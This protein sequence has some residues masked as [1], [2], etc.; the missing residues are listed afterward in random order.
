MSLVNADGHR[1]TAPLIDLQQAGARIRVISS[2]SRQSLLRRNRK[3]LRFCVHASGERCIRSILVTY[4]LLCD[5]SRS[6]G[7]VDTSEK[8][9]P[10]T[11]AGW[12]LR[13]LATTCAPAKTAA[14][15]AGRRCRRTGRAVRYR[16]EAP[17]VQP[18]GGGIAGDVRG[19]GHTLAAKLQCVRLIKLVS[20]KRGG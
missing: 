18:A 20:A 7:S 8:P 13:R 10:T 11:G 12:P 5:C 9:A 14:R 6:M 3:H 16:R 4:M 2:A 17:T 15:N 19:D 1:T